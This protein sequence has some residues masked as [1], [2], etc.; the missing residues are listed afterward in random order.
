MGLDTRNPGG[1]EFPIHGR[2]LVAAMCKKPTT[3]AT[4]G[5]AER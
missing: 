1:R 3:P 4:I 5:E 2:V